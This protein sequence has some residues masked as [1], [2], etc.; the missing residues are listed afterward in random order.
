MDLFEIA[1][2]ILLQEKELSDFDDLSEDEKA[3]LIAILRRGHRALDLGSNKASMALKR[4]VRDVLKAP[5]KGLKHHFRAFEDNTEEAVSKLASTLSFGIFPLSKLEKES[6]I[7]QRKCIEAL[8]RRFS[9]KEL[10]FIFRQFP[11]QI[12]PFRSL[13]SLLAEEIKGFLEKEEDDSCKESILARYC[14]AMSIFLAETL[15]VSP[16]L[17]EFLRQ[18]KNNLRREFEKYCEELPKRLSILER[19][20]KFDNLQWKRF[21]GLFPRVDMAY[22]A[23]FLPKELFEKLLSQIPKNQKKEVLEILHFN[24]REKKEQ[25]H[26]YVDVIQSIKKILSCMER[27]NS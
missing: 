4:Q 11:E 26:F 6:V 23:N 27:I 1:T 13:S 16:G 17:K 7:L 15:E 2:Q 14:V 25:L 22:V 5:E 18:Y 3:K 21:A 9:S 8:S 24:E 12:W 20:S 19:F 10:A